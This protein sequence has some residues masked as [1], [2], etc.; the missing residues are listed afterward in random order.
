MS[1]EERIKNDVHN[2]LKREQ[3]NRE[4]QQAQQRQR[5][6]ERE[7]NNYGNSYHESIRPQQISSID[8]Q[9]K[10]KLEEARM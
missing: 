5:V 7:F 6:E 1:E 4:R 9:T 10:L 3:E 8:P 2:N